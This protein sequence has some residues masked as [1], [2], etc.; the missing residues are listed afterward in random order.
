MKN[1]RVILLAYG[2]MAE[3]ALRSLLGKFIVTS[4]VTPSPTASLYRSQRILPVERLGKTKKIKIFQT[5]SLSDLH[6][7][8]LSERPDAVLIAS[9]NK[10]IPKKTL[11]LSKFINVH[12]GDLP[13]WRGRANLNWAIIMG[14]KSVGLTIHDAAAYLDAGNI[15]RQF[16]ITIDDRETIQTLYDKVNFL[17]GTHLASVVEDVLNG[18]QGIPQKGKPTYCCTRLPEDGLIDW[19]K[20]SVEIDRLI[21]ALTKPFPGAFSYL[22]G[23]KIT[24]WEAAI[25]KHSFKYEGRIAGRVGRLAAGKGVEVLTGDSSLLISAIT[26]C[27]KNQRA[28]HCIRSVNT[29]LGLRADAE[30]E[31]L[32][33]RIEIIE[34]KL[35]CS[36]NN[37]SNNF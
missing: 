29:T 6:R 2:G 33:E 3:T 16:K 1:K 30:F 31:K 18:Y 12:H 14:R 10:I 22:N 17:L 13:R 35:N 27:G 37:V 4:I 24:I 28:D 25:P 21:R 5:N 34:K 7:L 36:I 9:Y 11:S 23:K 26:Y 32:A 19:R 20:T 8:V 15:Y